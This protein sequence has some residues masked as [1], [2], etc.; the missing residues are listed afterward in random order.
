MMQIR[1][2]FIEEYLKFIRRELEA[3]LP[4]SDFETEMLRLANEAI[5][6]ATAPTKEE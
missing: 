2:V 1:D 6:Q 4:Y 5:H 3:A